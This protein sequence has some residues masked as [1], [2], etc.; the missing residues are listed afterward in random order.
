MSMQQILNSKERKDAFLKFLTFFLVTVALVVTAV[1]FNFRLPLQQNKKLQEEKV[2]YNM[3]EDTQ[4]RFVAVMN[5]TLGLLDS[6]DNDRVN[7]DII[8]AQI[9]VKVKEM[10]TIRPKDMSAY[11]KMNK[12]II[13]KITELKENKKRIKAAESDQAKIDNLQTELDK[14]KNELMTKNG[15]LDVLRGQ[16]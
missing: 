2:L 9:E 7:R 15:Q 11:S 6:L 8:T 12:V 1:Y 10:E 16:N 5:N 14:V 13:E 3:Q 4:G